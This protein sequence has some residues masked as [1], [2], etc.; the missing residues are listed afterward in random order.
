[1]SANDSYLL[2]E[3]P[4]ASLWLVSLFTPINCGSELAGLPVWA[5][6]VVLVVGNPPAANAGDT[7]DPGSIPESGRSLGVGNAN[8]LQYSFLPGKPHRQRSLAR[9]SYSG[10]G[11][12]RPQ[13]SAMLLWLQGPTWPE[14]AAAAGPAGLGPTAPGSVTPWARLMQQPCLV[15]R[16]AC[17]SLLWCPRPRLSLFRGTS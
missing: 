8:P 6:H 17:T 16:E 14:P 13:G 1:M 3:S 12:S 9:C 4:F 10:Q 15:S 7:R 5:S 11:T 2:P